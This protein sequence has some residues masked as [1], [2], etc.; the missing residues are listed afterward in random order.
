MKCLTLFILGFLSF[1]VLIK[2]DINILFEYFGF[3]D[4]KQEFNKTY[5]V[6]DSEWNGFINFLIEKIVI[7]EQHDKF[8]NG[9]EPYDCAFNHLSDISIEKKQSL[10]GFTAE[11]SAHVKTKSFV[12]LERVDLDVS[13][14]WRTKGLVSSVQDQGFDCSSCWAFSALGA[15]EGQIFKKTAKSKKLSEQNLVDCNRDTNFGCTVS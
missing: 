1:P 10:N 14:D 5:D 8:M 12:S 9:L 11:G 13:I 7:D 3:E 2:C 15:L 4:Y 6:E